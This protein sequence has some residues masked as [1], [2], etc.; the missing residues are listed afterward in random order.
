MLI[1][2]Q[3]SDIMSSKDFSPH[4]V[5][6]T[7]LFF[8]TFLRFI[9]S[10]AWS[11]VFPE[12]EHLTSVIQ[13]SRCHIQG[14]APLVSRYSIVKPVMEVEQSDTKMDPFFQVDY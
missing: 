5:P 1:K 2:R 3:H 13:H 9:F 4:F 7:G 8:F 14:C 11:P 10:S 12:L 6:Y